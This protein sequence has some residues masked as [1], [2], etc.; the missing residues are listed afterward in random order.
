MRCDKSR[1]WVALL[2]GAS[3]LLGSAGSFAEKP[4]EVNLASEWRK[5]KKLTSTQRETYRLCAGTSVTVNADSVAEVQSKVPMPTS[6]DGLDSFA[7]TTQLTSGRIDIAVDPKKKPASGVI[8]YGPRRTT[9]LARGGHVSVIAGPAGLA[10]G[11]YDGKEASVGIGSTWKHVTAGNMF[12]VTAESPQGVESKLPA[13]PG[14][15]VVNGPVLS[16]EGA[17]DAARAH[18]EPVPN[19][20]HYA[21]SLV[22]TETKARKNL[23]TSE[24][25][26]ALR[27]LEPGRY[28]LSVVAI[29]SMGLDGAASEPTKVN[30]VGV[31]LPPG[32][33]T[34]QGKV[35]LESLQ[36]LT[37]THVDGLETTYDNATLYFK[38][39][40]RAGLRGTQATT[41][42]LR[43]PGSTER[44]SLELLPRDLHTRVEI[45]PALA[46]WPRDKVVIRIHLPKMLSEAQ[47]IQLVPSVT[48]NNQAVELEWIRTAQSMETLIPTPPNYPGPWVLRAEVKD[49]HGIVLG[50][51]FLEIAST[52]GLDDEDIPREIHRGPTHAQAKR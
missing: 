38:A 33:Y 26:V 6:I 28:E 44:A 24:P 47:S 17:T 8:I 9:V 42:H 30:V 21:L 16:I 29:E 20:K 19:A 32:A 13:T 7:Y 35:Y 40:N 4:K 3:V 48:V 18:W 50:R 36:Q 15:V 23:D 31:V 51:N 25:S 41:L 27:G 37:L 46:R 12:T 39:A 45:S 14:H 52:A 34:S 49:Q 1:V 43:L 5:G 10:V 22:N 11:A 2:V